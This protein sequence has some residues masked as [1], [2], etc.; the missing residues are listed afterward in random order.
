MNGLML[1]CIE[2]ERGNAFLKTRKKTASSGVH[3]RAEA[4]G[5]RLLVGAAGASVVQCCLE[6]RRHIH[7]GGLAQRHC[8]VS[9]RWQRHFHDQR[10]VRAIQ[11][12]PAKRSIIYWIRFLSRLSH[13]HHY[14]IYSFKLFHLS[15]STKPQYSTIER[16]SIIIV[17]LES[18]YHPIFMLPIV[19]FLLSYP[20]SPYLAG[21][22]LLF[23]S[24]FLLLFLSP[25]C[26]RK[27]TRAS[28]GA[29]AVQYP[30]YVTGLF[31]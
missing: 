27:A 8:R 30:F 5:F 19:P 9:R 6:L 11:Y 14:V 29:A 31:Q 20:H 4:L 22:L 15:L 23:S 13:L 3:F 12:T 2:P 21:V 10:H 1:V 7:L 24:L 18:S 26:K 17:S 16:C 25:V 28:L